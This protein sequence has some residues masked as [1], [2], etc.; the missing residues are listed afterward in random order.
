MKKTLSL[1]FA[2]VLTVAITLGLASCGNDVEFN[3]KFI[4]DGEIYATVGT[5]GEETIKIP[6]N[7]TKDGYIFDGWYWD[8]GAWQKPFTANS[9]LDA[10]LSSDMSVYAKWN[11]IHSSSDWIID[12]EA[13]CN[14]AGS[15]H[16][17]CTK[18]EEVLETA[19]IDK[20]TTHTP[21]EAKTE[22]FVDSTCKVEGSYDEVVYCSVCGTEI[23][24][25]AK[26]VAKKTTHT[27]AEAVT[28]NFVDSTCKV[29]GS[30]DEVVYCSICG[31]EISRTEKTVAKKTTHTPAEAVTENFV[32]STCKVEGSYDEVVYCSVCNVKLTTE[33]KTIEKKPHTV[34]IDKAVAPDC[35][36]TGLTEGKHCS[37]CDTVLVAQTVVPATGHSFGEW[38][39]TKEPTEAESGAKRRDCKNCDEFETDV[40]APLSHDH[41]RWE[42]I[43]LEAVAPTCTETG[44]TEG[45]KCSGCGEILVAQETVK[46]LGHDEIPHEAKAPTCTEI[47]WDAYVTCSRCDYSTYA[48]KAALTHDEIK[49]DAKAPTCTEIGW[50]AYVTCS[51]CD[52]TTYAEKAALTHDDISHEA[53]APTCTEIGWDA[54]VTCSRCDY[55][56]YVEKPALTHDEIPHDAK[57][58]TCTEIGWDAYVTCSRCDY[59][60]YV[61]KPALTHDEVKHDAK[62]PTCTEIGWDAYVTCSRCDYTTYAPIEETGHSH[63]SVVTKPTCTEKGYTT[64]TCHCGDTYVDTYVDALGHN[65]VTDE[66]VA[67]TCTNTG[68]TEGSHCSACDEVFT[69]Q[70]SIDALG[71]IE[72]NYEGKAAT[73]TDFGWEAYFICD[74]EGCGY[75]SYKE[76]AA[77]GHDE[78][79]HAEIPATCQAVGHSSYVTCSRCDYHTDSVELPIVDHLFVHF[80][81]AVPINYYYCIHSSYYISYCE[82]GCRERIN[83][84]KE[85]GP[86]KLV[87]D[88]YYVAPGLDSYGYYNFEISCEH[89]GIIIDDRTVYISYPTGSGTTDKNLWLNNA[90]LKDVPY[91]DNVTVDT[92]V[93]DKAN[94][95]TMNPYYGYAGG[96]F[97][98]NNTANIQSYLSKIRSSAFSYNATLTNASYVGYNSSGSLMLAV[99]FVG[100]DLTVM[101]YKVKDVTIG[102]GSN[103]SHLHDYH[104]YTVAPTCTQRGFTTYYCYCGE[105]DSVWVPPHAHS[106][107]CSVLP[108]V[109]PTCTE[110]GLTQGRYCND[111]GKTVVEQKE[112]AA[113]GHVDENG[114]CSRCNELTEYTVTFVADGNTVSTITYTVETEKITPPDVPGKIG[115]TGVWDSFELGTSSFTVEAIYTRNTYNISYVMGAGT[116]HKDNPANYKFGD[117]I[118]LLTPTT[119]EPLVIF[120]GWFTDP[121]FYADSAIS[122]I[123]PE[124]YGDITLYAQWIYYRIETATGFEIDYD[125]ALPTLRIRVPSASVNFDFKGKITVSKNCTWKVYADEYSSISYDMKLVPI[126]DG[127]NVYYIVV[128]HPDGEYYT[129]YRVE[130]YRRESYT[131]EYRD[132][133]GNVISSGNY[134][135]DS[136]LPSATPPV[137]DGF[138]FVGWID[139]EKIIE[140]NAVPDKNIVLTPVYSANYKVEYYLENVDKTDYELLAA[141]EAEGLTNE[142]M[143]AEVIEIPHFTFKSDKSVISGSFSVTDELVLKVYYTR[144]TYTVSVVGEGGKV[145][146]VGTYPYETNLELSASTNAVY[147]EFIGWYS[148]DEFLSSELEL[149]CD[150]LEAD[151]EARFDVIEELKPFNFTY[152]DTTF[153]I[154]GVKDTNVGEIIIPDCVTSIGS[155]AF[156]Y[157]TA[158]SSVTIGNSVTSIGSDAFL[159]CY[160]LVEVINYSA[161]NITAGNSSHGYVGCYA[162]EVHTGESKIVNVDD[163]LF[164]TYNGVNYLLGYIGT[165]TELVL[166]E[167]YNGED[168]E[169]YEHAFRGCTNLTSVTIPEGVT[170]IGSYAFESCYNLVEIINHSSLDITAGSSSHG[171]V[172]YY[173]KEV[174]TGE[175]KIVNVDDYLFYAYDGVNYLLGYIGTDTDL[176]L[177]ENYNGEDYEIYEYAFSGLDVTNVVISNN[178]TSIGNHAFYKC[179]NLTSVTIGNG[180]TSIGSHTFDNCT[181]LEEIYF[182]A[183]AMNNLSYSNYVFYNAGKNRNGIRVVIGANVTKI[184][185]YLFYPYLNSSSYSPKITSV[186]FEEGS[187]CISIGEDAFRYCKSLTSITIPD[188]VT[189][190][191]SYAFFDCTS[192][193]SVIIPDSVKSIGEDAFYYCKS[194]TSVT[195]GNSVTSIGNH[196][197]Y[198]CYKL[199]E[200]INHS[201]L[202]IICGSEDYG[203]I[204]YYAIKL[205]KGESKIVN[206]NDYLFYTYSGVNYLLGYVGEDTALVFPESYNGKNYQI[207]EHAFYNNDDITSVIIGN[208]VTRIGYYA[209]S[210]CTGLT[211][212]TIPDSVTSIYEGAFY[213]CYK[214]VE[215]INHSTLSITVGNSSYGYAVYYAKEVHKGES[216]IVNYND[217][218]FYTYNGV[219]YL[220]GYVGEDTE[221]TL[222]EDYNGKSYEIYKYA[223][224]NRDDITSVAIPDSVTSIGEYAFNSCDSLTSITIPDSVTSIG[225]KTF[226]GCTRLTSITIPDSVTS[227]GSYAFYNCD[228]LTSITIPDSVTSI[229]EYAFNSCDSLTSVTIPDSVT[230]IGPYAFN[231][232]TSLT[233]VIFENPNGWWRSSSSTATSGTSISASNLSNTSTAATYLKST[234]CDYF[235]KR[236]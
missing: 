150:I 42:T 30:Y 201:S 229:G 212:V 92:L 93:L 217:Y 138:T 218:L 2:F 211:S 180:V 128:F 112:I 146:G 181:A 216:K 16:K 43:T 36:N 88:A 221:L 118:K 215:V 47:G 9:L 53:K 161:L 81:C 214:L 193:T 76:I 73:C 95:Q 163:Y 13:T 69:A 7:P 223:F 33:G 63:N 83:T 174:H 204:G 197:F 207:Y 202:N 71:H 224:Y 227:I 151:I 96:Y 56:T 41:A 68:L 72:H 152:T 97:K 162:K 113:L 122:E 142:V 49:H 195:I 54:Y 196:A 171:Y 186:E 153:T 154:T 59:T 39:I 105:Y 91:P 149:Y 44:L 22:N 210:G 52:Y 34:V 139:G 3:V 108:T 60:T 79:H 61:E 127:D 80:E 75:S 19:A 126:T 158:L 77:L 15:K 231:Y 147:Y 134:D 20:L 74:R 87:I 102:G 187:V 6:E 35:T 225:D 62:A 205:H 37:V 226:F 132:F 124:T 70:N 89:C 220:I 192:L 209:F 234:Y 100:T 98:A 145:E 103:E 5:N 230:S 104:S 177:P 121:A 106:E 233:S 159:N 51:R 90:L 167:N 200:V 25:T 86:H 107:N 27:P 236:S 208:S 40:V 125:A 28:E 18:C 48:E 31:M 199:V 110:T 94:D 133:V 157:C 67:P 131:Y 190:I 11:C 123:S 129:Q 38:Y 168:Y 156:R 45:K 135:E 184:P 170:S 12:K 84:I 213:G 198:N 155:S 136:T 178:V 65:E 191:G 99:G 166:P 140:E 66:A 23:S 50:D 24:R 85:S 57:A 219:N 101:V 160:K 55:T 235:W 17:E 148:G 185:A 119:S 64:H 130:I 111:C 206:Y 10:P 109:A 175:S 169:I 165:D 176:V 58:P 144:N 182:N 32:D 21:G 228:S 232:C 143:T 189:S 82:Y 46:V 114:Y 120:G 117:S 1:I 194:L 116:N 172:G 188:G 78:I 173:A 115:H 8:N 29:E 137:Y 222:P 203:Y 164:Y 179:T 141:G 4:V 14:Q 26:T 183:T